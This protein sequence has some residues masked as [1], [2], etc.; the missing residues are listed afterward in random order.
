MTKKDWKKT[1]FRLKFEFGVPEMDP[2]TI[3][4]ELPEHS[5]H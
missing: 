4:A 3:V 2:S 1:I 5:K